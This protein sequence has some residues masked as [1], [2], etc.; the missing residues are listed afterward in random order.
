MQNLFVIREADQRDA[1]VIAKLHADS[2]RSAYRGI[3]TDAFLDG[4]ADEDRLCVWTERFSQPSGKPMFVLVAEEGNHLV[5][6]ICAFPAADETFGSL[7]DN[8]H[9]VPDLTG[10]GIGRGLLSDA[11]K[12]LI[13]DGYSCGVFLWVLEK[14]ERAWR[15][16]ERAQGI[17][18]DSAVHTMADGQ[19]ILA[20]RYHWSS[21][22]SLL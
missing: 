4:R 16:Y 2:W 18:T 3:L 5:G 11:A 14:N 8:L 7:V 15:F 13:S 22:S 21:P 12:H 17:H 19:K 1:P 9:V 20:R 6:F 10:R